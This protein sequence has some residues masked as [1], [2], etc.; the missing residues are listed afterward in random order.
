MIESVFIVLLM[1]AFAVWLLGIIMEHE[2]FTWISLII[3]III[4][5]QSLWI[6]V[7]GIDS[8]SDFVLQAICLVFIFTSL[9]NVISMR[10]DLKRIKGSDRL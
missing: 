5:A 7:P 10:M 9:I 2:M 4:F 1:F 6:T 8:Y 3:W